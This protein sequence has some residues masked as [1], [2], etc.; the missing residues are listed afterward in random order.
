MKRVLIVAYYFPPVAAS[1]CIRPLAFCRHLGSFGWAP[2]VVSTDLASLHP[3]PGSD[4]GLLAKVPSH[5]KVDRIP[6]R[7]LLQ[8]A[9][10]ARNALFRSSRGRADNEQPEIAATSSWIRQRKELLLAHL[11]GFPDRHASWVRPAVRQAVSAAAREPVDVVLATG[12]PWT[13]LLAG[14][15]IAER[16][17]VPFIADFRDPWTRN[18][19]GE[20]HGASLLARA[21]RLE[22]HVVARASCVIANTEE[23]RQQFE[24]DY[25][26]MRGKFVTITNGFEDWMTDGND[27]APKTAGIDI[28]RRASG[29]DMWHFGTVYGKRDPLSLLAAVS[30]LH[31]QGVVSP[32][33]FR[34]RFVGE[35]SVT[36]PVTNSLAG[37]LEQNGLMVRVAP[38]SHDESLRQMRSSPIL[39]A[40]QPSSPLQ[41]PAKLYEYI[42][43]G[44]PLLVVGGEGA[45]A[46][47]VEKH[48]LGR[49]CPDRVPDLMQLLTGLLTR[50]SL[51]APDPSTR[52]AFHYH[53]LTR[54]LAT[55]L[56]EAVADQRNRACA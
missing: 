31:E 39:L 3:R 17:G 40:I 23:L 25:P 16:L 5:I 30:K 13:G 21:R 36:N 6:H 49:H 53:E 14:Q 18:P 20:W 2:R 55:R 7:D 47:L 46:A 24:R 48:R 38:I 15:R 19:Y 32:A 10:E 33:T 9:I 22:R 27:S 35:W 52:S 45:T 51:R 43:A 50:D 28:E 12:N 11:I 44:R 56:D 42:A 4:E 54:K 26:D 8:F 37:Q 34:L 41:I 29:L 1:G